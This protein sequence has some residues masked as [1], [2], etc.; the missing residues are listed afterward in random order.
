MGDLWRSGGAGAVAGSGAEGRPAGP[1]AR[2][3]PE[4]S[5]SCGR[6][7]RRGT[8]G[9]LPESVYRGGQLKDSRAAPKWRAAVVSWVWV[10]AA[11]KP[12]RTRG[13]G[14]AVK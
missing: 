12:A 1:A 3:P 5:P 8:G 13:A 10:S 11:A 4:G 6:R 7:D 2:P 14:S 9:V